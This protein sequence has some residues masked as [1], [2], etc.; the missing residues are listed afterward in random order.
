MT[1]RERMEARLERRREWAESRKRKAEAGF[2]RAAVIADGIPMG[3][4]I[5]VGHHS[6]KR[7]RRDLTKIDAGM[8]SGVENSKMAEHH[9]S[10]ANGIEHALDRSIFSDDPDAVEQLEAKITKLEAMADKMKRANAAFRKAKGAPGWTSTLGVSEEMAK[11]IEAEFAKL[12]VNCPW[13]KHP[14][15]AY[16]MTNSRSNIRRLKQRIEEI[17]RRA[18]AT[19]AA[20]SSGGM[21]IRLD[22][23]GSGKQWATITF[24][25]KPER[26][27][28]NALRSAGFRWGS[29]SWVGYEDV[30][31]DSV[32]AFPHSLTIRGKS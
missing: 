31:P 17:G 21:T 5:L 25:E 28:L 26:E 16:A 24:A 22:E 18:K 8:R 27:I 19:A 9:L 4:P 10:K 13:E 23:V 2:N 1:R 6:E 15:P 12:L 32:R 30:I 11:S 29:G 7:H 14:Y 3:Q 20:E